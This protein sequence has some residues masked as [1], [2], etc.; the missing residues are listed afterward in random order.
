MELILGSI[1]DAL[2]KGALLPALMTTLTVPDIAGSVDA[3][4]TGSAARYA[5]WCD[6][7]LTPPASDYYK[8][9]VDGVALYALRCKLLHEGL[10]D[11]SAA[12]ASSKSPTAKNMKLIAFNVGTRGVFHLCSSKAASGT[13]QVILRTEIFCADLVKGARSWLAGKKSDAA[14]VAILNRVV[15]IRMSIPGLS[16]GIPLLCSLV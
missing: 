14:A 2:S 10:T 1:D 6:A 5:A 13:I 11:P 16:N 15:D 8:H 7:W 4:G 9:G 12:P 3:P